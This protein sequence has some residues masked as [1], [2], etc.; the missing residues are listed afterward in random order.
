MFLIF[1][2]FTS[3]LVWRSAYLTR[4]GSWRLRMQVPLDWTKTLLYGRD[5]SRFE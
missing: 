3:W 1:S 2:G 5:I 4:L